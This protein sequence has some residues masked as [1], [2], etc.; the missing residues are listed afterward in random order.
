MGFIRN[1]LLS[2]LLKTAF[3]YH[4]YI[5]KQLW[6]VAENWIFFSFCAA[7]FSSTAAPTNN[8]LLETKIL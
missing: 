8:T 3:A 7:V 2:R 4:E 5:F 6:G 1:F